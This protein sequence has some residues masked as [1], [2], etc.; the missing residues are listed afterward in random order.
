ME[1]FDILLSRLPDYLG[2]PFLSV[3]FDQLLS[4]LATMTSVVAQKVFLLA[5]L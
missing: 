3:E 4:P 2:K 1:I 5:N